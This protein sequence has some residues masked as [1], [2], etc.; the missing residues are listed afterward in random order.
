MRIQHGLEGQGNYYVH[1]GMLK[2]RLRNPS[3]LSLQ[4]IIRILILLG[5]LPRAI[6]STW[7]RFI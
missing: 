6:I 5:N 3:R 4:K 7:T 1:I 2:K